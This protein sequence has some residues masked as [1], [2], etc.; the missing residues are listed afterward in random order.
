M[1]EESFTVDG[2][3]GVRPAIATDGQRGLRIN[4]DR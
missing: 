2:I 1:S 3:A 4:Q